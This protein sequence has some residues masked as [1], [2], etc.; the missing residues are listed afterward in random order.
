[1]R[2]KMLGCLIA[3]TTLFHLSSFTLL[4][5]LQAQE[6]A[7]VA[8][9]QSMAHLPGKVSH[10]SVVDG[11]LYCYSAD[12]LLK[13]QRSGQQLLGFWADTNYTRYQEGIDFIVRHP[14]SGQ[15]FFTMADK[16][17]RS[18]LYC[19]THEGD[20]LSFKQVRLGGSWLFNKG[21]TVHHPAFSADGKF[22]IFSSADKRRGQGGYDLWYCQFDGKRWST[23]TNFGPR[24]NT[25]GDD[26][27]PTIYRGCLLFASNG[28]TDDL[29]HHNI[30]ATR[31]ISN[32]VQG[33]TVGMLQIGRSRVQKL[34]EPLNSPSGNDFDMVIDTVAGFGYWVS[35]REAT[36]DSQLFSFEG[37]LDGVLLWGLVSDAF[38]HTLAG[39]RVSAR[40]GDK[41]VCNTFTD[42][43]GFYR[44]YL[45]CDQYYDLCFQLDNYFVAFETI[46]TTKTDDEL[47][48]AEARQDVHLDRLP[49][50]ERIYYEDLFGPN[51]DVE[52]SYSGM[53]RLAPL[54]RFLNDNPAASVQMSLT[55]DLTDDRTFNRL[56]TDQRIQSLQAYL[57]PLLPPTV[58][59]TIANGCAGVS[60]CANASGVSRLMVIVED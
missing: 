1:M 57:Y 27:T 53:E 56:L 17:G 58:K 6:S 10:L 43:D 46:N 23:P 11:D 41:V 5:P 55:N 51:V 52:L 2:N 3:C 14:L 39:V 44:M 24:I 4:A 49:M 13:A 60:G 45:Q 34:P 33:D 32:R 12:I 8:N 22:L 50:G 7:F 36:S 19:A 29:G 25:A 59:I 54:V 47:L 35:S 30:Y 9:Q 38:N 42:Q 31:L 21:M 37:S 48:I 15:L 40:Q 18:Y 20:K 28:H 16:K 26:I